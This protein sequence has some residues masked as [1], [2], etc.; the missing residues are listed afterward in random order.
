MRPLFGSANMLTFFDDRPTGIGVTDTFQNGWGR[1]TYS[2]A[3][4]TQGLTS[5]PSSSAMDLA[6]GASVS[7]AFRVGGL[8][9]VGFIARI[10]SNGTLTCGAGFCQGNYGSA[11]P[12]HAVRSVV[13]AP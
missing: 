4:A 10:F 7:G 8:P 11:F 12:H 2:G 3:G 6:T 5:L 9:V 13:P 1:I